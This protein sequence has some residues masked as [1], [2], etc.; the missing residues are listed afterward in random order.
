MKLTLTVRSNMK[1]EFILRNKNLAYI[2]LIENHAQIDKQAACRILC[3][4]F[5]DE[6]RK[7]LH[8]HEIDEN[9]QCWLNNYG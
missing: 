9:L 2:E 1:Y 6:Y 5:I 7:Y 8:P 3:G 4:S